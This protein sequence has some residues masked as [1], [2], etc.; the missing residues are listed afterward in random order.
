ML[1]IFIFLAFLKLIY[2]FKICKKDTKI[3]TLPFY[4]VNCI[5]ALD[6]VC[7]QFN[8]LL[9]DYHY[10]L[11]TRLCYIKKQR[12][13]FANKG[14]HIQ[15]YGF[16]S[17][18][19]QMGELDHKESWAPKNWCFETVVLVK[20]LGS[21]LYSK[22]IKP[23]NPKGNQPWIFIRRTDPEAEAQYFL[24]PKPPAVKSWLI[25]KDPDAGKDCGQE[26]KGAAE[27]ELS[28]WDHQLSRHEFEQT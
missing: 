4:L 21:P 5:R 27:D 25:G 16:S 20:T 24:Q 26:E 10:L 13:H 23:V 6:F 18:H 11:C 15:S 8:Y 2:N 12:H 28:G 1:G 22:K 19:K 17:S 3:Y 9:L 14:L 7:S